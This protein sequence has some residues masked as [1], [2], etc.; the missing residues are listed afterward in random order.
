[1]KLGYIALV[2][3]L[4]AGFS[5]GLKLPKTFKL[6]PRHTE[7]GP[8]TARFMGQNSPLQGC[9]NAISS[10]L[11]DMLTPICKAWTIEFI[12]SR[13]N[14]EEAKVDFSHNEEPQQNRNLLDLIVSH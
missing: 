6:E 2:S 5:A 1:M 14:N 9:L 13:N 10:G 3:L 7:S 12:R 8:G 11:P 4:L